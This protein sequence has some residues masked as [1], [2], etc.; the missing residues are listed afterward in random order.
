MTENNILTNLSNALSKLM[1]SVKKNG[2][3]ISTWCVLL[4]IVSYSFIINP[5][6]LNNLIIEMNNNK[7]EEHTESVNKILIADE[8]MPI[9]L[10]NIRIK[11][12]L[13]RVCLLELHNNSTNINN[14]SFL[15]FSLTYERFDFNNDSLDYIGD[16]YQH[17]RSN[18]Y[19]Q[20]FKDMKRCGYAYY[21]HLNENNYN[22]PMLKKIKSNGTNSIILVPIL[23]HKNQVNAILVLSSRDN[24]MNISEIGKD[25]YPSVIKIKELLL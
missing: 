18:E 9:L 11:H 17:Q 2:I 4:F 15:Y 1:G 10:D 25:L 7:I 5:I 3:L 12:N 16:Y 14:V 8:A 22:I 24:E 23:N 19:F 13:D 6:N 20:V 21:H